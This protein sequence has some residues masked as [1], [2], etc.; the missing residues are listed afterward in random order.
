MN[1][2]EGLRLAR[3][4]KAAKLTQ[5][6]LAKSAGCSTST[7]GNIESGIRG[8]GES[9]I[10]IARALGVTPEYLQLVTDRVDKAAP[11]PSYS[12]EALA[13]AWLL[14]QV[15]NRLDKKTAETEACAVILRYV[16]K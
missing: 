5:F 13:L 8:Y 16:N 2:T 15:T 4:R 9:V 10:G 14:D 12:T 11:A 1:E 3:L 7:I 6:E